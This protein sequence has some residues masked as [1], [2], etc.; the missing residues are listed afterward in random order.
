MTTPSST[1]NRAT[2][3]EP[4]KVPRLVDY[5]AARLEALCRATGKADEIG[6]ILETYRSLL[7]PW[8]DRRLD[9]ASGWVSDISDDHTPVE[10][11]VAFAGARAEVRVLFEPQTEEPT[12]QAHRAAGLAFHRRLE[13]E[14]GANLERFRLLEELF[15]PE[16]MEGA[17]AVWSS[18]V[19]ASGVTP[20]FK[21]YFN[22]QARGRARARELTAE[23]LRRLGMPEAL[24]GLED[25]ALR[26]G[27]ER[28]EVKYFAL[29]L[30]SGSE[31]RVK[32]YV[33]HH[34][35]TPEELERA[36]S[37]ARSYTPGEVLDFVQAMTAGDAPLQARAPFT[38]SAFTS[39]EDPRPAATTVYVPVCAYARDDEAA[40][41]RILRYMRQ[42]RLDPAP[43]EALLRGFAN[44]PLETG[45]GMQSWFALRRHHGEARF[46]V[47]LATEANQVYAPGIIPA[48]TPALA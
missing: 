30:S 41:R 18:V 23:A 39:G 9:W 8:G 31:A 1:L 19:F 14:F 10:L 24:A 42:R 27:S 33:R 2:L 28:D 46:T 6:G 12:L 26:R 5:T 21:T 38:C 35:A 22:P 45:V 36:A 7:A 47:Y 44:R 29:D 13:R 40:A 43:Y 25:S 32:V 11:S 15:L 4:A 34:G 48:P 16:E 20:A 17:F 37:T 3:H